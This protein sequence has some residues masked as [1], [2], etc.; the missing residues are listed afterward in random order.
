MLAPGFPGV[1]RAPNWAISASRPCPGDLLLRVLSHRRGEAVQLDQTA[2]VVG[3]VLQ[4][5]SAPVPAPSP[6]LTQ[7]RPAHVVALGPENML[8]ADPNG[9]TGLV[10][11]LL[12]LAQRLVA[13]GFCDGSGSSTPSSSAP[14]RSPPSDKRCPP[15]RPRPCCP[16]PGYRRE[17]YC[18]AS[19][20]RSPDSARTS[21]VPT[22]HVDMVLVAV[23]APAVL[24]GPPRLDILLAPLC[25][26]ILPAFRRLASLY[27]RVLLAACCAVWAPPRSR[28]RMIWPPIA[29]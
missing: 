19:P 23:M 18:R 13:A 14:P 17:P 4:P 25:R 8:D 6:T 29:R 10:A 27:P 11:L 12:A 26:L 24:L 22:V 9:R 2:H 16:H 7:Q 5:D 20:R 1:S 3:E 21:L 15:I 28:R